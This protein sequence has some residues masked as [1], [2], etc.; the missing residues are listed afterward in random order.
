MDYIFKGFILL[1]VV[2][3]ASLVLN[4][5]LVIKVY[6]LHNALLDEQTTQPQ[7]SG[8]ESNGTIIYM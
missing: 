6:N 4:I 8:N 5:I 3:I 2:L 1:L 7:I